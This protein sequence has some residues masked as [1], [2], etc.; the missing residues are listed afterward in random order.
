LFCKTQKARKSSG[1][2]SDNVDEGRYI[3]SIKDFSCTWPH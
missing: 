1:G 3:A 2:P